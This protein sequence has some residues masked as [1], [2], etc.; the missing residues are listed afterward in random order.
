ML[1]VIIIDHTDKIVYPIDI[2]TSYH[3]EQDF[4]KSYAKYNYYIQAELYSDILKQSITNGYKV[5]DFLFLVINK[6]FKNPMFWKHIHNDDL[7]SY[8][9]IGNKIH[10]IIDQKLPIL[11]TENQLL[12]KTLKIL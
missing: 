7:P 9:E 10:L 11:P 6:K 2:K 3:P 8:W 12:N 1:D 5:N 4:Y